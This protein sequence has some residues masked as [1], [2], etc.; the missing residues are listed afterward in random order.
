MR[1]QTD[2]LPKV[3]AGGSR[4]GFNMSAIWRG[5][6]VY[7]TRSRSSGSGGLCNDDIIREKCEFNG[8]KPFFLDRLLVSASETVA[9]KLVYTKRM[10]IWT[11]ISEFH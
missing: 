4:S 7:R 2:G 9:F 5:V 6:G 1:G 8:E 11:R 3:G 10:L